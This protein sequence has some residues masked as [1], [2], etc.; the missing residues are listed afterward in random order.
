[1]RKKKFIIVL[2]CLVL[3][4]TSLMQ[5][6]HAAGLWMFQFKLVTNN[7]FPN[8][9][10]RNSV[11]YSRMNLC[12]IDTDQ[13]FCPATIRSK[14]YNIAGQLV[15]TKTEVHQSAPQFDMVVFDT[16]G[17]APGIYIIQVRAETSFGSNS[18]WHTLNKCM[19]N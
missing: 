3:F 7:P 15:Y 5:P 10:S 4:S 6:V 8:P 1:M 9:V 17:M 14:V 13:N 11:V 19:V 2:C 12:V 18:S 16:T